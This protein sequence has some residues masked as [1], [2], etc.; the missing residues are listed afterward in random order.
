MT[1]ELVVIGGG[2][3]GA[4]LLGGLLG[5]GAVASGDVAVV[6]LDIARRQQLADEFEGVTVAAEM[7]AAHSALVAVK[8]QHVAG[9]VTAATAAGATR[10]LSIAAGV[11]TATIEAAAPK[12]TAVIRS[13][14]NTPALVNAGVTAIAPGSHA[15]DADLDWAETML[16]SVGLVVRVDEHQLDAV[17]GLTGSGPAY[18]FRVAESLID[19]GAA[20]GLP[21]ALLEPMVTQLLVG[22][23]KLLAERGDPTALREAVTSPGGTTAAGLAA[24]DEHGLPA[25]FR[26]AVDA[27]T[28]RG[29][30]LGR[31][32]DAD[33]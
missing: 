30:E 33:G 2:N 22:S 27:A 10:V 1:F 29:R 16:E 26:A 7:P 13:M 8:P 14:P 32:S 9:A 23:A 5:S 18:V 4:A 12:G 17:T 3:M 31:P 20:A 21:E 24:L 28:A 15:G 25:A 11:T 6:E 19:A